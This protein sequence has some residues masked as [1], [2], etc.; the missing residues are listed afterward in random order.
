MN[1]VAIDEL[2]NKLPLPHGYRIE[3]LKR[4]EIPELI[5]CFKDWFPDVTVGAESCYQQENF[6]NREV[7]IE[8]EP[9]MDVIVY[10]IKKDQEFAGMFSLQ[11]SEYSLIL[12]GRIG[13]IAKGNSA[14]GKRL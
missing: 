2:S 8:G 5:R 6:Y 7:S 10:L 13:A 14:S 11:R 9:E 4:S 1:W 12:Y 3:Q